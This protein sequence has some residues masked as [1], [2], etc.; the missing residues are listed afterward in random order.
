MSSL[1]GCFRVCP[2]F[3]FAAL[4][5][6]VT[7]GTL[8]SETSLVDVFFDGD[9]LPARADLDNFDGTVVAVVVSSFCAWAALVEGP[10]LCIEGAALASGIAAIDELSCGTSTAPD[11]IC[12]TSFDALMR[13]SLM[14]LTSSSSVM[15]FLKG[16]ALPPGVA[17]RSGSAGVI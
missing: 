14:M 4:L 5:T 3:D 9:R 16:V 13:V 11:L 1:P 7:G 8:L 12:V 2:S 6:G 10:L 17:G 15:L